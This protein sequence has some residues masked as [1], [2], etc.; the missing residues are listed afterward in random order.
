[1]WGLFPE[2]NI[3]TYNS[4]LL[5]LC[6][7]KNMSTFN[8]YTFPGYKYPD[9]RGADL[10]GADLSGA[11][12]SGV[13]LRGANLSG[14]NLSGADLRRT[15]LSGANLS[16]ANLSGKT[17]FDYANLEG[18][19]L[20]GANLDELVFQCV[21]QGYAL[22]FRLT[23]QVGFPIVAVDYKINESWMYREDIPQGVRVLITRKLVKMWETEVLPTIKM[24]GATKVTCEPFP[25]DGKKEYRTRIFMKFG[26]KYEAKYNYL[27]LSLE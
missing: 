8:K 26:F 5:G 19:N 27:V 21:V 12:L 20:E 1:M 3:P 4:V 22:E 13:D 17:K 16:N 24:A 18:A 25:K 7:I 10:S 11:N 15:D 9:Y 2:D 6:C 14:A 23:H